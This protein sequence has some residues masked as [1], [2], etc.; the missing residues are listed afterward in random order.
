LEVCSTP[1]WWL[2]RNQLNFQAVLLF[3]SVITFLFK[4]NVLYYI[5]EVFQNRENND[6]V[7]ELPY[8]IK[9]KIRDINWYEL[10]I[11]NIHIS[12]KLFYEEYLYKSKSK[13][14]KYHNYYYHM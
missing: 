9:A 1:N 13:V 7:Q 6:T 12:I 4:L 3:S 14:R 8:V 10:Y 5:P 2:K 11:S